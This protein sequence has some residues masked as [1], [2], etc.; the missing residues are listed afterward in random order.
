MKNLKIIILALILSIPSIMHPQS[1]WFIPNHPYTFSSLNANDSTETVLITLVYDQNGNANVWVNTTTAIASDKEMFT[2]F[3]SPSEWS[4]SNDTISYTIN[5]SGSYYVI[6]FDGSTTYAALGANCVSIHCNCVAGSQQA[7]CMISW[8]K[9]RNGVL[10]AICV[11]DAG[12]ARSEMSVDNC[13]SQSFNGGALLIKATS[14][15]M[16]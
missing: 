5:S 4:W 10:T 2:S 11:Q 8:M 6:R 9:N 16:N 13:G 15:T 14:I 3:G 1:T 12:C 7:D